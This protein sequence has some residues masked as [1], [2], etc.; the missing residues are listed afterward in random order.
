[1]PVSTRVSGKPTVY[2]RPS[3]VGERQGMCPPDAR[4]AE[5]YSI[6]LATTHRLARWNLYHPD[7][8]PG[9]SP[10]LPYYDT[11][12]FDSNG[13]FIEPPPG[14]TSNMKPHMQ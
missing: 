11:I 12:E 2:D 10:Q 7:T 13:N 4:L 14:V 5:K 9:Q 8:R 6:H 1:M 3:R